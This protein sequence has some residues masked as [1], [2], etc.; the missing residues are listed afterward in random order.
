MVVNEREKVMGHQSDDGGD[1]LTKHCMGA[2][3]ALAL[4]WISLCKDVA[5]SPRNC[6]HERSL[7]G[8]C[9]VENDL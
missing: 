4:C 1:K 7:T 9:P 2:K 5:T 6:N 3:I 8:F